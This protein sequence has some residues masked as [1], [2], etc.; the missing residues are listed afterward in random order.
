MRASMRF[1]APILTF[2]NGSKGTRMVA[3]RP[4]KL[5]LRTPLPRIQPP[6][7]LYAP[8]QG[9]NEPLATTSGAWTW[10][11]AATLINASCQPLTRY[12]ATAV[13]L[14]V[15]FGWNTA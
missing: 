5:P 11:V 1:T 8:V 13:L 7:E 2:V 3:P 12:F 9:V 15:N 6:F 10:V 14:F 4:F